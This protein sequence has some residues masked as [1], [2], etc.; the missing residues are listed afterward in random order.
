MPRSCANGHEFESA[1]VCDEPRLTL[2]IGVD[3]TAYSATTLGN[4]ALFS[5]PAYQANDPTSLSNEAASQYKP[6]WVAEYGDNDDTGR[7]WPEAFTT[8]S[9]AWERSFP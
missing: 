1:G 4:V 6:L 7:G 8:I 3:L 2:H 9:Q 5:T